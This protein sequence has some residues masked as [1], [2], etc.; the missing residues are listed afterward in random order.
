MADSISEDSVF[1]GLSPRFEIDE[2]RM[3][4]GS[5]VSNGFVLHAAN[6]SRTSVPKKKRT[7]PIIHSNPDKLQTRRRLTRLGSPPFCLALYDINVE[8]PTGSMHSITERRT[9][10]KWRFYT[11]ASEI[12]NA[13]RC[14]AMNTPNSFQCETGLMT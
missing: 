13:M 3:E 8:F 1:G 5:D 4:L 7:T 14:S 9:A 10:E 12:C 6:A 11:T 2:T